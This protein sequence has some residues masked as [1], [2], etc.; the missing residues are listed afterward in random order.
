MMQQKT[1]CIFDALLRLEAGFRMTRLNSNVWC[2]IA[3]E[4]RFFHD[5]PK[6]ANLLHYYV[7]KQVFSWRNRK[8]NAYLMHYYV[9]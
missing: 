4:S 3:R 5:A 8:Q 1:K 9:S 2:I 6:S 7:L